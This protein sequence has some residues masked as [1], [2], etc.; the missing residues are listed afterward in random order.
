MAT[1]SEQFVQVQEMAGLALIERGSPVG[2][3]EAIGHRGPEPLRQT[4]GNKREIGVGAM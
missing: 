3:E 1:L 2:V 4:F